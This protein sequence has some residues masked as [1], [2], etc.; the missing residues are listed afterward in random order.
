M[1]VQGR[2]RTPGERLRLQRSTEALGLCGK[3]VPLHP[4][5][6]PAAKNTLSGLGVMPREPINM[7]DHAAAPMATG[8]TPK[9][10]WDPKSGPAHPGAASHSPEDW[11]RLPGPG[12]SLLPV[13]GEGQGAGLGFPV[14][15]ILVSVSTF[16]QAPEGGLGSGCRQQPPWEEWI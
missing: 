2:A 4:A 13:R 11:P 12:P 5:L 9:H 6:P 10:T 14:R 8:R 16:N 1:P 7:E 3:P 15:T